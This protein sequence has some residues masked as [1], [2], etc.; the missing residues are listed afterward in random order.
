MYVCLMCSTWRM[1][2][3]D[4]MIRDVKFVPFTATYRDLQ[5]L[6]LSTKHRTYPLVNNLGDILY[7]FAFRC[8]VWK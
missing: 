2:V 5:D 4:I 7:S 8:V 1:F 6:L 3:E